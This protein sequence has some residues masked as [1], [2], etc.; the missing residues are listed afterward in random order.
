MVDFEARFVGDRQFQGQVF[1][2]W[3][4]PGMR[5]ACGENRWPDTFEATVSPDYTTIREA[6]TRPF[7]NRD[8]CAVTSSQAA[9]TTLTRK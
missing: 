5:E 3:T 4:E 6:W 7:G 1:L 2:R 9:A 8:T